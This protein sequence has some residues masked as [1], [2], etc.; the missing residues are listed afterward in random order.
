MAEVNKD[1][2]YERRKNWE[3]GSE[4][5]WGSDG[6]ARNGYFLVYYVLLSFFFL[7]VPVFLQ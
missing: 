7:F 5:Q 3:E 4:I 1:C 2:K 6:D